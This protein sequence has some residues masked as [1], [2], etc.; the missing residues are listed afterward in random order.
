[1]LAPPRRVGK[2]IATPV[3]AQKEGEVVGVREKMAAP[4]G[5][6]K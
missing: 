5:V 3:A 2:K 1:M 6:G 4:V